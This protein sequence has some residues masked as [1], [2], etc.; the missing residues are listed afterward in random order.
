MEAWHFT[1]MPYPHLPPLDDAALDPGDDPEQALRSQD[2]RR[3]L[4][5]LSRRVHDRRRAR[6][7]HHAQ[8][9]SPDRHLPRRRGAAVGGDPGAAD[10]ERPHLH[11][12]QSDGQSRRSRAHRRGD[13]D[14]RLHFARP[15]RCRLRARR[16]L[17]DLRRQHQSRRRPS[18]A[19]GRASISSVKAWTTHDGP[20][21][22][23]AA[24]THRRAVNVWPRPYQR[25]I[26]R[27]G[28]PARATRIASGRSPGAATSSPRSCSR[29]TR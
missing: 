6:P 11:P 2:R 23:R 9:A 15:A 5:P 13:G 8:R 12:R 29:T 4:Q 21:T 25:R 24:S 28:S 16:A 10:P 14:D 1:E 18:S 19:C 22:S 17:R 3:S 26:R 27:S 20:S 7:Q